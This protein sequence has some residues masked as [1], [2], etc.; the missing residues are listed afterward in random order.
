MRHSLTRSKPKS[1]T[2]SRQSKNAERPRRGL[3]PKDDSILYRK[4]GA[5]HVRGAGVVF[6][7]RLSGGVLARRS[8][9]VL[10]IDRN[11]ARPVLPRLPGRPARADLWRHEQRYAAR[12]PIF[13]FHG[14]GA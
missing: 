5:D 3:G 1:N 9:A 2:S 6:A 4:H 14:I 13:H 10:W 11:R 12:D 7:A 8:G